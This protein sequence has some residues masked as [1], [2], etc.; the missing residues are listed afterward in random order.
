M[1]QL[2]IENARQFIQA[3]EFKTL[4][5]EELGWENAKNKKPVPFLIKDK[6]FTRTAIAELS[7]AMVFEVTASDSHIPASDFRDL[8]SKEI[9]KLH[10]EHILIFVDQ[11]RSQCIWRWL[12]KQDKKTYARE[13]LFASGQTGDA[14]IAKIAGL[15]VDLGEIENNITIVD[16]ARKMRTALDVEKVTRKFFKDYQTYYIDF[17]KL[18]EGIESEADRKWYASVLLNRLMFIYFLQKKFFLAGGNG[19]Y[20]ADKLKASKQRDKDQFYSHFLQHLFFEGFA[21]PEKERSEETKELIGEIRYLN[22]GLFLHHKIELNEKGNTIL[23]IIN[24]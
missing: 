2:N 10:F 8:V 11:A 7:G 17:L 23:I 1:L 19:D 6:V 4:F 3:F 5:V 16:V 13:H 9:Q 18:I 20:L 12:K 21:K 14:F 15:L 24:I 22:G